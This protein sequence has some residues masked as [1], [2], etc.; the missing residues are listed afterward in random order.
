MGA[1]TM[2]RILSP[3][4]W[5]P[6]RRLILQP[7]NKPWLLRAWL[8]ENGWHI[9]KETLVR[10]G[11]FLYAV[12]EAVHEPWERLSPG[13]CWLSPALLSCG[14]EGVEEY[15]AR[16]LAILRKTALGDPSQLPALQ[17]LENSQVSM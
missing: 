7:Q 5:L 4:S 9:R 1:Q 17:E 16:T 8:S 12:M 2:V 6:G 13:Q 10:D 14:H 3:A 11:R 15:K